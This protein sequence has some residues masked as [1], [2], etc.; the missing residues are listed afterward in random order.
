[1]AED[2]DASAAFSGL[3]LRVVVA[4]S[5]VWNM[6]MAGEGAGALVRSMVIRT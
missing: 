5:K 2:A 1:L 6:L 3:A 4:V